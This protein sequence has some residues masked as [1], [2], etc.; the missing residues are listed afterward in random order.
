MFI[1]Y[2][3]FLKTLPFNFRAAKKFKTYN[4][5]LCIVSLGK[6]ASFMYDR[7][8]CEHPC[9]KE[10]P[11]IIILPFN[12]AVTG[13]GTN[14]ET[15]FSTHPEITESSFAAFEKL[16]EFIFKFLPDNIIV[17]I[18]GGSS[19]LIE[20]SE[21]HE[22]MKA[23]N[24]KLVRSGLPI[25]AINEQR[26]GLSQIKGGKLAEIFPDIFWSVFVMSDIPFKNGEFLVGSMPFFRKDLKNTELFKIADSDTL[27]DEIIKIIGKE[28]ALSFRKFTGSVK[29]LS[30]I[31]IEN[32]HHDGKDILITGEPVLK[33]DLSDPGTGGR[34][35]HLA[36][37]VLPHLDN[38]CSFYALSSDGIDGKSPFAGAAIENFYSRPD[39][40]KINKVL[41]AFDSGRFLSNLGMTVETGYTGI[42]L[43][44]F[45]FFTRS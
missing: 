29:E 27:H 31:I 34:M 12:S 19:A 4:K 30:D 36:L 33:V 21:N 32:I 38:N 42:N 2:P 16:N 13:Y 17:L 7:F 8:I 22:Q 10:I 6:S 9:F 44:D 20:K 35:T 1:N 25:T 3:D 41:A 23:L 39:L 43:N 18:S 14:V 15:V 40:D 11:A 37:T 45:V 26:I 28:P 24:S 5:K